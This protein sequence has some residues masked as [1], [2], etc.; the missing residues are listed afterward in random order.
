MPR[1]PNRYKNYL[2]DVGALIKE[3]ALEA[4]QQKALERKGTKSYMYEAGRLMG[5]NEVI[6][7]LQQEAQGFGIELSD[8]QLDDI[9]PDQ[10]LL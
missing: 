3:R 1:H 8:L 9:E 7:I 5:F 2:F 6:S 4:R 10:D